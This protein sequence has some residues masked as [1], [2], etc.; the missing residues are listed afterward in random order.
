MADHTTTTS[1]ASAGSAPDG[2][3]PAGAPRR[4]PLATIIAYAA[5]GIVFGFVLTRAEVI[6]WFRIQEMFRFQSFHMYGVFAGALAVAI[7]GFRL[8]KRPGMRS[9]SGE[10]IEVPPKEMG[11]GVRYCGGGLL[12]GVGWAFT[13]ACPGPFFALVGAGVTVML[14]AIVSAVAGAWVYGYLRPRLPH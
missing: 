3:S 8:L 14:V 13:G 10:P 12:F 2:P 1:R 11:S 6:S 4:H 5:L 7:P 9:L